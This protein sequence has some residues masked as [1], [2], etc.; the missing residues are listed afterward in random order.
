MQFTMQSSH[1]CNRLR[2]FQGGINL[3]IYLSL[4]LQGQYSLFS[5]GKNV[6]DCLPLEYF[7]RVLVAWQKLMFCVLARIIPK[8]AELSF[9]FL[10]FYVFQSNRWPLSLFTI[11]E[12]LVQALC[13]SSTEVNHYY[14]FDYM[15]SIIG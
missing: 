7:R 14:G 6:L 11:V 8:F 1:I 2:C 13:V 3:F 10:A 15:H 4:E 9:F 5:N 12:I